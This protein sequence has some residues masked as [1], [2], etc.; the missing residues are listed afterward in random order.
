MVLWSY[1]AHGCQRHQCIMCKRNRLNEVV[2]Y[3]IVCS[4][5][6]LLL[7]NS[8]VGSVL[9]VNL[10][11]DALHRSSYYLIEDAL[12]YYINYIY[13]FDRHCVELY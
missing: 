3:K 2:Q 12:C 4:W 1:G 13:M 7:H 11:W 5:S 6:L 10:E 8:I 9:W